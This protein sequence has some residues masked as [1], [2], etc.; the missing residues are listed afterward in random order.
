M[1]ENLN[2][3]QVKTSLLIQSWISKS[4]FSTEY[5]GHF[6]KQFQECFKTVSRQFWDRHKLA[7]TNLVS[8]G[9]DSFFT[10]HLEI[11]RIGA[12]GDSSGLAED[13]ALSDALSYVKETLPS[14]HSAKRRRSSYTRQV[15]P[16][17]TYSLL[18]DSCRQSDG[19]SVLLKV[20]RICAMNRFWQLQM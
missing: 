19:D 11:M 3:T 20:T 12:W 18:L 10:Q 5:P 7:A 8:K 16:S 6:D 4:P 15:S 17:L 2:Q 14:S 13:N 1:E 9:R